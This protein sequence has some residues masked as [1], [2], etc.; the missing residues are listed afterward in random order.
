MEADAASLGM[1][2]EE[3]ALKAAHLHRTALGILKDARAALAGG[4][5]AHVHS[6]ARICM[7]DALRPNPKS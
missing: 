2:V 4:E 6:L 7:E 3:S 1:D 5:R